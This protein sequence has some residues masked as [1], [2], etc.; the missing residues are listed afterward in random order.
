TPSTKIPEYWDGDIP[1]ITSADI[2]GVKNIVPR[3]TINQKAIEKGI[4]PVELANQ[5]SEKEII[6]L[7]FEPG[8]SSADTITEVSGRGVGMDVVKKAMDSIGGTM[9]TSQR[10]G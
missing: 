2:Y 6:H 7:I 4:V 10:P 8:F 3:R 5:M 9:C 1:W